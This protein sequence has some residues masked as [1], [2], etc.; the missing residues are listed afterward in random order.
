MVLNT[1][2][3][4]S[5]KKYGVVTRVQITRRIKKE[6]SIASHSRPLC[7]ACALGLVCKP[8][9]ILNGGG[10]QG[11]DVLFKFGSHCKIEDALS[12]G[13]L[14]FFLARYHSSASG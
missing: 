11:E 9:G 13:D 14:N 3:S 2:K 1:L 10:S 8:G 6:T 7:A 5:K 4:I 12:F